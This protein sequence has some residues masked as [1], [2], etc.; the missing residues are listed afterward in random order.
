MIGGMAG[1]VIPVA[2]HLP[3][4]GGVLD[5]GAWLMD[6]FD[7]LEAAEARIRPPTG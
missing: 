3:E 5:Q 2:G 7:L 6:A 4:P 1:G